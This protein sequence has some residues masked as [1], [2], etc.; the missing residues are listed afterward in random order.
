MTTIHFV[1]HGKVLNLNPLGLYD[2]RL[3]GFH[4]SKS[5]R[6]QALTAAN[7]LQKEQIVAIFSNPMKRTL[8]TA[9]LISRQLPK[10]PII[11]T[12]LLNEAKT[13]YD[14][15]PLSVIEGRNWDVYTGNRPL[16]ERLEDVLNCTQEFTR[17][18]RTEYPGRK[19]IATT[20]GDI[21]ACMIL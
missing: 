11:K 3:S 2:G 5:R 16:Y 18:I 7:K 9:D 12:D 6:A 8:E 19:I 15:Q 4:L 21:V 17:Q 1:R 14:G 10:L 13:P 20:H